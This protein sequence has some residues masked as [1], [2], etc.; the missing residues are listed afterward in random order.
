MFLDYHPQVRPSLNEPVLE[1][2][3]C[4]YASHSSA[5][6]DAV[7]VRVYAVTDL[8]LAVEGKVRIR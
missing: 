7:Q 2:F 4:N 6:S 1:V 3:L 8:I 5:F